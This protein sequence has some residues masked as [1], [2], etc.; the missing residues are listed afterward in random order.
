[1][2]SVL[3]LTLSAHPVLCYWYWDS[4]LL[5]ENLEAAEILCSSLISA[6]FTISLTTIPQTSLISLVLQLTDG[7]S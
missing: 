1:M 6:T 3:G 5:H 7:R 2:H 4:H